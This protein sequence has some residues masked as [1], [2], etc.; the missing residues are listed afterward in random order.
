MEIQ[1]KMEKVEEEVVRQMGVEMV[2]M[3][4]Q[5]VEKQMGWKW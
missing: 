4:M 1:M 3:E 5:E 2:E